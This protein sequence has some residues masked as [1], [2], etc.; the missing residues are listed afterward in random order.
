[1]V[2]VINCHI[3]SLNKIITRRGRVGRLSSS[4]ASIG[5]AHIIMII[6]CTILLCSNII[7]LLRGRCRRDWDKILVVVALGRTKHVA[8]LIPEL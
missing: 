6:T 8:H 2:N 3:V 1:M 7:L 4:A 5:T